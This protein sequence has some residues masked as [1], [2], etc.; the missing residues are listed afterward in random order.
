MPASSENKSATFGQSKDHR[1]RSWQQSVSE[2]DGTS[3][4]TSSPES[5]QGF[6]FSRTVFC[7]VCAQSLI[8]SNQSGVEILGDAR[9]MNCLVGFANENIN[10]KET[11]HFAGLPSRSL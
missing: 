11:L 2:S 5:K 3:D 7:G 4:A 6:V 10:I 8:V 9:V 1:S